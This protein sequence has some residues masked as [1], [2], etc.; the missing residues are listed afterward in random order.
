MSLAALAVLAEMVAGASGG[1]AGE[2]RLGADQRLG[3]QRV[4][5]RVQVLELE[6]N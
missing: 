3:G 5:G 6:A 1:A 2:V 4:S